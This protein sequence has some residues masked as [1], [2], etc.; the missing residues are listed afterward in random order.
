MLGCI[1]SFPYLAAS[2]ETAKARENEHEAV[3]VG[4]CLL[5]TGKMLRAVLET[6][7]LDAECYLALREIYFR[8]QINGFP[9]W[10]DVLRHRENSPAATS[11]A[12]QDLL[13]NLAQ[14]SLDILL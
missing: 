10:F 5:S 4:E 2:L 3:G 11:R 7:V 14:R 8:K 1:A 12:W 9:F 13:L 6:A